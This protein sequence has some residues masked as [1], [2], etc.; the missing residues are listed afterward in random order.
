MTRVFRRLSLPVVLGLGIALMMPV[1]ASAWYGGG[2]WHGGG[3]HGG[4]WRGGGWGWHGG[5]YPYG[6]Y[7]YGYWP[8]AAPMMVSPVVSTYVPPVT[9]VSQDPAPA[10]QQAATQSTSYYCNNPQGM[11]P[12]VPECPSG[13]T[14]IPTTPPDLKNGK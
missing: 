3:W 14:E 7:G 1:T 13:W 6:G 5:F 9:E 10:P 4:G 2:G 11:Y 12:A 8:Y